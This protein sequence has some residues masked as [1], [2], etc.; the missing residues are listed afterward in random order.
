MQ[1]L[2]IACCA[3]VLL[4]GAGLAAAQPAAAGEPARGKALYESRCSACHSI[5]A[6]RV[7]PAHRGVFGR[8]AGG[9]AGYEYSPALAASRVRWDTATLNLWLAD[10]ERL[11]PGQ[12][13]GYQVPTPQDRAD[14]VAYLSSLK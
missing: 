8:K 9:A 13:M 4:A 6:H 12:R 10:P 5:D 14:L 3:V 1:S 2:A 11:I 7:G